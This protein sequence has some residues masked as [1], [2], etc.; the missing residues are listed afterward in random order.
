MVVKIIFP[1][2]VILGLYWG[3]EWGMMEK[4]METTLIG[5]MGGCQSYGPFLGTLTIRFRIIIGIQ[6]GTLLLTTTH[7]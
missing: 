6:K 1:I 7:T 3:Y 2:R 4:K 5:Y